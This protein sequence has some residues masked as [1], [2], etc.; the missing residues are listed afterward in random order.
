SIA[1]YRA[2]LAQARGNIAGTTQ[3]AQRALDHLQPGD[4]LGRAGAAGFLGLSLWASGEVE[5]AQ[6]IFAEAVISMQL[7]GNRADA[8]SSVVVLA[9]MHLA[10]G[11]LRE[12]R[13]LLEQAWQQS[14]A[15]GESGL[16]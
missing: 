11:R 7:A 10:Q 9:D 2:A 16:P 13:R 12:A 3:Y 15:P 4:H 6:R 14:A 1:I 8:L 5:A